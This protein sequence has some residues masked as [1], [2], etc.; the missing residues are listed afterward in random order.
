MDAFVEGEVDIVLLYLVISS[1][2][3]NDIVVIKLLIIIFSALVIIFYDLMRS[4]IL[5]KLVNIVR[6]VNYFLDEVIY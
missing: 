3:N 5:L 6:V 2:F 1:F 4:F